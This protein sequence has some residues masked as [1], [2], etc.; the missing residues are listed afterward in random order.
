M[1]V[2]TMTGTLDLKLL[3]HLIMRPEFR[4]ETAKSEIYTD[5]DGGPTDSWYTAIL[6]L[7]A[8]SN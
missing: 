2:I 4:Y 7:V 5:R 3:P 8:T 1:N 6:G